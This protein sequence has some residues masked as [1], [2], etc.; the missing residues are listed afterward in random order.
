MHEQGLITP[1][2]DQRYSYADA[3]LAHKIHMTTRSTAHLLLDVVDLEQRLLHTNGD[4]WGLRIVRNRGVNGSGV[5]AFVSRGNS[6][7]A[8]S[9]S[10]LSNGIRI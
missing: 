7:A 2:D 5:A 1:E 6:E 3:G 8:R 9:A 10:V 4:D